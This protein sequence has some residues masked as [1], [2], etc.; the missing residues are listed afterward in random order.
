MNSDNICKTQKNTHLSI[1]YW[2]N[3]ENFGSILFLIQ[4]YY[5]AQEVIKALRWNKADWIQSINHEKHFK[6]IVRLN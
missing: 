6:Y 1:D 3:Y 5:F 2:T 4:S